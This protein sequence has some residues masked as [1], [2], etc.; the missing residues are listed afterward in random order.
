M[1]SVVLI[2]T[3]LVLFPEEVHIT[4]FPFVL[5]LV[6]W[7]TQPPIHGVRC[8]KFHDETVKSNPPPAISRNGGSPLLLRHIP[9]TGVLKHGDN[10]TLTYFILLC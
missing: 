10:Y 4:F 2:F 5:I 6:P 3:T 7:L 9:S 1:K 8:I